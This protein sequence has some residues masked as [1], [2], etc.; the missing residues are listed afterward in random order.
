LNEDNVDKSK[1]FQR[2]GARFITGLT[3]LLASTMP[4]TSIAADEAAPSAA[5][6]T[7]HKGIPHDALYALNFVGKN[8]LAT[9]AAGAILETKDGGATW[10]DMKSPTQA[11]L[12]GIAVNGD[13][14]VIVGQ[15]GTV[16][17]ANGDTWEPMKSGSDK[18]L[19][20]VG[21]NASGLA[22]AVGEFGTILRSKDGGKSWEPRVLDWASYRD[23]GYE[24]HIYSVDVQDSGRIV[25]GAEFTYVLISEDGGETFKLANKGEKSIFAMHLQANGTGYAAG[26]EGLVMKTSDNG[27]TWTVLKTGSDA[28]LFGIWASAQGEIVATGMRALLRSSDGGETFTS[29][30]DID[31][32]RN[33]FVPVAAGQSETKGE[34][35]G[36]V[37]EVVYIAG[38]DGVIARVLR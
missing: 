32:V 31:V 24:P 6:A 33:W 27:N 2:K 18:R 16:L 36:L 29:S 13:R 3:L 34:G 35:G 7:V 37:Q 38:H 23:D 9:G 25:I 26:Q 4:L 30:T 10:T 20:N 8:G 11:G 19:L 15:Q 5:L 28:N 12:F 14:R 17:L 1:N 22:I 21:M